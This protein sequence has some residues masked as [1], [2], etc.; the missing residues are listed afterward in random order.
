[1][2]VKCV[3]EKWQ[4]AER[5]T[6]VRSELQNV[7]P[8]LRPGDEEASSNRTTKAFPLASPCFCFLFILPNPRNFLFLSPSSAIPV[9]TSGPNLGVSKGHPYVGVWIHRFAL[10]R[11]MDS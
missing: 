6:K 2:L 11:C 1:M 7:S 5:Q 3:K 4:D 8:L 9:H 10:C